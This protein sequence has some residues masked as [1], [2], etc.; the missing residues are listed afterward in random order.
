MT[1]QCVYAQL[2]LH[3]NDSRGYDIDDNSDFMLPQY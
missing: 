3:A 1:N 2:R